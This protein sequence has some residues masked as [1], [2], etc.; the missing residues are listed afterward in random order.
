M[1]LVLH[2][3]MKSIH[4]G[5]M[6]KLIIQNIV[7]LIQLQ[8]H[9]QV[10]LQVIEQLILVMYIHL[11]FQTIQQIQLIKQIGQQHMILTRMRQL[12]Y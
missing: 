8:T 3:L 1:I 9:I 4:H 10:N 7:Q 6:N 5:H 12:I 2:I 11:Y